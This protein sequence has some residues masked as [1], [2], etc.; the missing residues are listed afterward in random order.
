MRSIQLTEAATFFN[1]PNL[2]NTIEQKYEAV[3]R[4][5]LL[6][7]ANQYFDPSN[8]SVITTLPKRKPATMPTGGAP[9]GQ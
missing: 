1:D 4:Q 5:D 7:V 9:T 2:I 6:R 8:R 3:T